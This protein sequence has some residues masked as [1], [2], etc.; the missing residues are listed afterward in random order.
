MPC[1]SCEDERVSVTTAFS[2]RKGETVDM[3][4]ALDPEEGDHSDGLH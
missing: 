4:V 3:V 1:S 2:R